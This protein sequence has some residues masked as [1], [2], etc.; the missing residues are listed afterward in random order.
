[1]H[2]SLILL[3]I[4]C[5][6]ISG[7][8]GDSDTNVPSSKYEKNTLIVCSG[9]GLIN[10]MNELIE[11]FEK[12]TGTSIEVHYGGSGE[13]FAIL[14]SQRCDVFIPGSYYY[15]EEAMSRGHLFNDTVQNITLH[16]PVI[17]VPEA[18][19]AN[20]TNL[21]DLTKTEVKVA[22][23]DPNGPAIGK[24]ARQICENSGIWDRVE[25]NT[26]VKTATVNQ[27]LIYVTT[28][29]VDA[30]IIWKDMAAW[31][32]ANGKLQIIRLPEENNSIKTIPTAVSVYSENVEIAKAFNEYI[33]SEESLGVWDKW[34]F[35]PCNQ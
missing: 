8:V 29:Q 26:V 9:A 28:E 1:M 15:T 4:T 13:I 32:E 23:G 24:A 7:C 20:I 22:L 5:I 14:A 17:A 10:P 21:E 27:L 25:K 18:N 2:V 3:L 11:N 16:I 33:T 35:E 19:P 31:E 6:A 30:T 34:G 12:D